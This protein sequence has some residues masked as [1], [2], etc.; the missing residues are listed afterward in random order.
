MYLH[1]ALDGP[2]NS[3]STMADTHKLIVAGRSDESVSEIF[4]S[5]QKNYSSRLSRVES[6]GYHVYSYEEPHPEQIIKYIRERFNDEALGG[7]IFEVNCEEIRLEVEYARG[8]LITCLPEDQIK[9]IRSSDQVGPER[10]AS[11][12]EVAILKQLKALRKEKA[13]IDLQYTALENKLIQSLGDSQ[14]LKNLLSWKLYTTSKLDTVRMRAE[15]PALL[16]LY[17]TK[18]QSR[19]LR[20][21]ASRPRRDFSDEKLH[22]TSYSKE[23]L[24]AHIQ[25][26]VEQNYFSKLGVF[27]D[28]QIK[29]GDTTPGRSRAEWSQ[30]EDE[31][32]REEV[33]QELGISEL[34]QLHQRSEFSI[35]C[36]VALMHIL[37]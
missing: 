13:K 33:D 14:G 18:T 19:Q 23:K 7:N 36:R 32:L 30:I 16:D 8:V 11:Q 29:H 28:Y 34:A 22:A 27:C 17:T 12:L 24:R 9:N 26:L 20:Y 4:S 37:D 15:H 10:S 3:H 6:F 2:S 21:S 25:V 1:L 35:L 5:Q 31:Q